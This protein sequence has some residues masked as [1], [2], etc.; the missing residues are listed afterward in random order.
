MTAGER[1]GAVTYRMGW[2]RGNRCEVATAD[3]LDAVLDRV[4][5]QRSPDGVPF[6]VDIVRDDPDGFPV[7]LQLGIGHND[8]SFVLYIGDPA[9]GYAYEAALELWPDDLVFDY[10]GQPTEYLPEETR[11]TPAMARE[12]ARVYVRTG[13]RPTCVTWDADA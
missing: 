5:T 12:V 1:G 7:G 3:A 8:R 9:S 2:G 6:K 4:E 10:G 11:V 13:E